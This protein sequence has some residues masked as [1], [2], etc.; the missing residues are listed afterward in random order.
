[1]HG[2]KYIEIRKGQRMRHASTG[3]HFETIDGR[4]VSQIERTKD[5]SC[6][7]QTDWSVFKWGRE[8]NGY[9]NTS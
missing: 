6:D 4:V 7:L 2:S 9:E 5:V 1:M 8:L 3:L